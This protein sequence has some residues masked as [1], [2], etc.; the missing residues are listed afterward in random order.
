MLAFLNA[1]KEEDTEDD[2]KQTIGSPEMRG[3]QTDAKFKQERRGIAQSGKTS[4]TKMTATPSNTIEEE[5]NSPFSLTRMLFRL[6]TGRKN[7][8]L[9]VTIRWRD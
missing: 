2:E 1:S 8:E 6:V 3:E 5:T 9:H 7:F 4:K